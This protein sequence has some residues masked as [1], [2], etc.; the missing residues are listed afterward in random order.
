M[1]FSL[2]SDQRIMPESLTP[3]LGDAR[4]LA[5]AL[6]DAALASEALG[7]AVAPVPFMGVVLGPIALMRGGSPAQQA[8][9]LPKLAAG[10][11][12][13]GGALSRPDRGARGRAGGAG[14]G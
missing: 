12:M 2:T 4:P 5:R 9:W 14:G 7:R 6:L 11:G 8:E 10:E 1:D 3:T 13:A